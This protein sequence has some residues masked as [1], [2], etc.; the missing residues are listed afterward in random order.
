MRR[1]VWCDKPLPVPQ[2]KGHRRREFCNRSCQQKHYIW[3]QQ[4]KHDADML[5]D[6]YWREAYKMLAD[7]YKWIEQRLQERMIEAEEH[8]RYIDSLEKSY[9]DI[10]IDYVARLKA[11]GM[12]EQDIQEFNAYWT[13]H[14]SPFRVEPNED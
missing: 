8:E 12:N 7:R 11:L 6:P 14:I 9:E 5:A 2:H 10:K 4:I 1:C 13:A 3:H